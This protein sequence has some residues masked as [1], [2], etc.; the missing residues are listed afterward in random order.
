[1][2]LSRRA[3]PIAIIL[4][5]ALVSTDC[6]KDPVAPEPP[7]PEPPLGT[8]VATI[9]GTPWTSTVSAKATRWPPDLIVVGLGDRIDVSL[10]LPGLYPR[11]GTYSLNGGSPGSATVWIPTPG[12]GRVGYGTDDNHLGTSTVTRVDTTGLTIAGTFE[13]V[14]RGL[15]PDAVV[16]VTRGAFNVSIDTSFQIARALRRNAA[17]H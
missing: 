6:A 15:S 14:G 10:Y 7:V 1:M 11:P 12:Y 2:R 5:L 17:R 9:D 3:S 4:S 8:V 16:H 13:F